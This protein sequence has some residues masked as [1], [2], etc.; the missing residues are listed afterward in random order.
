MELSL[1]IPARNEAENIEPLIREIRAALDGHL[2]YE[3][4]FVD[5]GSDDQTAEVLRRVR[6]EFPRL[7][8]VRHARSCGQSAAIRSGIE[9][10]RAPWVLT[11]DGDGQDDPADAPRLLAARREEGGRPLLVC[12]YRRLRRDGWVKRMSSRIANGVRSRLLGDATPD[13]GC[14]LKLCRRDLFLSLPF[15]DHM[16]RFLPA[17]VIRAGGEVTSVEVHHRP[18]LRGTSNYGIHNRLW[19]GIV[20]MLGVMWL[21]RRAKFPVTAGQ[22]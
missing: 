22:E 18:R 5:D 4:V 8:A 19:V 3:V 16:H 7:R 20:D 21:Q 14:G 2:D 9:A 1:V 13:T 6:L 15:F 12:G 17:L 10:A 11:M